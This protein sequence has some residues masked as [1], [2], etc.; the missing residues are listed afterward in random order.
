ML[1][2]LYGNESAANHL[3]MT[4]EYIAI[5]I[6]DFLAKHNVP[7]LRES[8]NSFILATAELIVCPT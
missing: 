6:S 8:P 1:V 5:V 4:C 7:I 3:I 2:Q